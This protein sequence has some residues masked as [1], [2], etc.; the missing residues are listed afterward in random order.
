MPAGAVL[1]DASALDEPEPEWRTGTAIDEFTPLY[2]A[3]AL[4]TKLHGP[5][6]PDQV[7]Q[8]DLTVAALLLGVG[9]DPAAS[10]MAELADL[11]RRRAAGEQV[12]WDDQ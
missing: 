3:F 4:T 12:S 11:A 7:D 9:T 2:R 6:S 1:L 8:M 5:M 10:D